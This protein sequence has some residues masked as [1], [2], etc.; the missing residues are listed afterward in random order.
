MIIMVRQNLMGFHSGS[1]FIPKLDGYTAGSFQS[2]GK[3]T[4][5]LY[6]PENCTAS[7][8]AGEF[9]AGNWT[10]SWKQ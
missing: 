3:F 4:A 2:D 10:L 7:T 1:A 9:A 8:P 6:V 5:T